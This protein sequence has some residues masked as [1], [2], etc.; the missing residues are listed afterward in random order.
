MKLRAGYVAAILAFITLCV[1]Y[2]SI[3]APFNSL[4][5]RLLVTHLIN[6][7]YFSFS[8][9][10]FPGGTNE[11][12]R[13]LS[14]LFFEFDK[15][16]WGLVES[17]MHL[18][19]ILLH[20]ANVLLIFVIA[21][22]LSATEEKADSAA[23]FL[24]AAFFALHPLNTEA[25]D[26]ISART[27]LLAGTFT[28]ASLAFLLLALKR[29]QLAWGILGAFLMFLGCLSKEPAL[30]LL[31]G[32]V[33]FL[34]MRRDSWSFCSR[35]PKFKFR[36]ALIG[37]YS[38][39]PVAY[40]SLRW[41]ALHRDRGLQS[42]VNLVKKAVA[43]PSAVSAPVLNPLWGRLEKVVEATG[44]YS[45]K[46]FI[47]FP[48][49]FG[50]ATVDSRYFFL[51]LV[52]LVF[53][54][55]LVYRRS[56]VSVLLLTSASLGSSALL[57]ILTG[58]GW[59]LIAE[60]YMYVATGPFLIAM[61][62]VLV[63]IFDKLQLKKSLIVV[64]LVFLTGS[65]YATVTRNLTWQSNLALFEDTV[66]KSPDFPVAKNELAMALI[67]NNRKAEAIKILDSIQMPASQAS[68]LNKMTVYYERGEYDQARQ[69]LLERLK[70]GS[71]YEITILEF[72][73]SIS[74]EMI[75][76]P[77]YSERK[78]EI[79]TEIRSWLTRLENIT[80]NPFVWYRLGR[81]ALALKD[82]NQARI[83]FMEAAK[84]LPKAS[85]YKEPAK[86][87]AETL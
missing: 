51:G 13:P 62:F 63:D 72:L 50:I 55:W 37:V 11:Y 34:F 27:D 6:K 17:F 56:L 8:Q 87:L 18:E 54:G 25:V 58:L 52:I 79:Y 40:L 2:P 22:S 16:V 53:M 3:S 81:V 10:F 83:Y 29:Y 32:V 23:P 12:Y 26:W 21:R 15:Y 73:V 33:L 31:P 66:K 59:V 48:L 41:F 75:N 14:T 7:S 70:Q 5:D 47:P 24:A 84:R 80:H 57:V 19:N 36:L 9:H 85:L 1:Y 28:Y 71:P 46:L 69:F 43:V 65:A 78:R 68:S 86:K 20:V 38:L 42:T 74:Y 45:K 4:D 77:E 60:R 67:E 30:F 44:F 76:H 64:V 35:I 49:N 82:K 39:A 61:A